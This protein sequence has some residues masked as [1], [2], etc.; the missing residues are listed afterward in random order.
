[1]RKYYENAKYNA[2]FDRC[3]DVMARMI[4]RYGNQV[5]EKQENHVAINSGNNPE[6][7]VEQKSPKVA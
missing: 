5:L 4:Q 1:M 7:I 2:A 6:K 3:I